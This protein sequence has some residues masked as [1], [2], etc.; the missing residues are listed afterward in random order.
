MES[1][2]SGTNQF[3]GDVYEYLR[4]TDLDANSWQDKANAF[5]TAYGTATTLP[6]PVLQWNDFGGM[7]GGPIIK[8]KLFFFADFQGMIFN[9]PHTAQTN[10]VIPGGISHGQFCGAVHQPGATFVNGICTNPAL[11]LYNRP[12]A[13]RLAPGA[14][15]QQ[16]G[17][18]HQQSGAALIA[19]P[20]FAP[21]AETLN[22]QTAVTFTPGRA[23]PRSTG[24]RRKDHLTGRYS[25][26]IPSTRLATAPMC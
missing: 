25:Q 4:N 13:L 5:V 26:H 11:Q 3:H 10:T 24:R 14:L 16:S 7:I 6:R 1:L 21:E 9:T 19:S 18:G 17:A 8:D 22:Y 2:K 12:P 20:Y 15:C 23:T